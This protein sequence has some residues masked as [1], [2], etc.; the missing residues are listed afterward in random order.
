MIV[1]F[2]ILNLLET[3]GGRRQSSTLWG[4]EVGLHDSSLRRQSQLRGGRFLRE[5]PRY[6][7]QW[8]GWADAK[9]RKVSCTLISQKVVDRIIIYD[10][11]S[12]NLAFKVAPAVVQY[13]YFNIHFSSF[14]I[15]FCSS[16]FIRNLFPEVLSSTGSKSRPT[17]AGSKIKSQANQLVD[18][19]MKCTPHY[20]RLA[21]QFTSKLY[22][23]FAVCTV[24]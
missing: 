22:N 3:G 9:F 13:I 1:I 15:F 17:T 4:V 23:R 2:F 6:L 12:H 19:L 11:L 16:A 20:I 14:L 24:T 10:S 5:K 21:S 7:L 8:S 18:A